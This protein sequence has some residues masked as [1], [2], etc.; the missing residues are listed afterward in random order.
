MLA[1][2]HHEI[3]RAVRDLLRDKGFAI[4]AVLSIG[5]GVGANSAIFSLVDQALLRLLPVKEPERLVLLDW[6]G[7][8]VGPGWGSSNLNS[9]PFY[10]DLVAQ[11]DVFDGAFARH[12]TRV[13][14]SVETVA[15]PVDVEIVT[16]SYFSVLGIRPLMGRL[17][18]EPDDDQPGAH[19]VVVVSRD[20]WQNRLGGRRDIVGLKVLVNKHPMTVVGVAAAGFRGIDWGEVPSLWLPTMMKRVM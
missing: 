18:E 9:Y 6:N 1:A 2:L 16:G 14:L 10:R 13:L 15:E 11:T 12:P 8:S 7:A 4:A 20:Y 17:I 5:L 3:R 19:P